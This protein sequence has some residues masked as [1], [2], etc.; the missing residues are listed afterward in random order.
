ME[1]NETQQLK[2]I[3]QMK[4]TPNEIRNAR[5]EMADLLFLPHNLYGFLNNVTSLDDVVQ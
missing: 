2:E 4:Y 1:E 5:G 3:L